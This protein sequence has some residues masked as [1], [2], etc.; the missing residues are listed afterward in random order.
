[1]SEEEWIDTCSHFVI[2]N[3]KESLDKYSC[4]YI[5]LPIYVRKPAGKKKS[6]NKTVRTFVCGR[7]CLQ[8]QQKSGRGRRSSVT[9]SLPGL[10]RKI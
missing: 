2:S 6:M 1:M 10:Y 7:L 8:S 3:I 5:V 4:V 9:S